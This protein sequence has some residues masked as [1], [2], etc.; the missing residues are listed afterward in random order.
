MI[1]CRI[2]MIPHGDESRA[3]PF[4]LIEIANL[5]VSSNNVGEYA[6]VLKKCPPYSGALR[7]AW[8]RGRFTES[9]ND[10]VL[11]GMLFE[12]EAAL[13]TRVGG[14]HRT[15]RGVYDLVYRALR[16]CGLDARNPA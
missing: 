2:E 14:H 11:I 6:V 13:I 10:P 7:D 16:A 15:R 8:R 3:Y 9:A 4:G 12:T 1:R 5:S